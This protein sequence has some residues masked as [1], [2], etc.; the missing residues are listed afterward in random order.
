MKCLQCGFADSAVIDSRESEDGSLIRR[1]RECP[2]CK[3][4]FTTY[5]RFELPRLMVIKKDGGRELFDRAKLSVGVYKAFHKRPLAAS[6]IEKLIDD[7]EREI[8]ESAKEEITTDSIGQL[9]M[10]KLESVDQVAYI[11]FAAVY[12]EFRDLAEFSSEINKLTKKTTVSPV[13]L[14]K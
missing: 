3:Y 8:F 4:R 14:T 2:E 6:D 9:V 5:E 10:N 11:R 7:I 1:R 12:R 13:E